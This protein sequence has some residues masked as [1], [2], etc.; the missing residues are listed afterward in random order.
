MPTV[1][2]SNRE[3]MLWRA[4]TVNRFR[5]LLAEV[6]AVEGASG[7]GGTAWMLVRPV[8]EDVAGIGVEESFAEL[9]K[10][11]FLKKIPRTKNQIPRTKNQVPKRLFWDWFLEF[12]S[13]NLLLQLSRAPN[14]LLLLVV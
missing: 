10:L 6:G 13:W 9:M 2:L 7:G 12:G 4:S 5:L 14:P 3:T 1:S 11:R 8:S